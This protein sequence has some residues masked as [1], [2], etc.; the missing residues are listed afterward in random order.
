M[1]NFAAL[2]AA[3]FPL[4]MK[5]FKGGGYP[6]PPS[7]RGINRL[8]SE[9][10]YTMAAVVINLPMRVDLSRAGLWVKSTQ[11]EVDL[12]RTHFYAFKDVSEP[13]MIYL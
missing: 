7:V 4:F 1:Q 8:A 9:S 6:P 3:V 10:I 13:G 11:I 2:P 5:N 12:K